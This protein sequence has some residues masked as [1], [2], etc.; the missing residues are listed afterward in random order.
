MSNFDPNNSSIN[1][2]QQLA[3][4]DGY[5]Q[6]LLVIENSR[7][8]IASL[9]NLMRF[10]DAKLS[11]YQST[12]KLRYVDEETGKTMKFVDYFSAVEHINERLE[13]NKKYI[14]DK[15]TMNKYIKYLLIKYQ[16]L[17]S[18]Y[19]FIGMIPAMKDIADDSLVNAPQPIQ[20]MNKPIARVNEEF[21]EEPVVDETMGEPITEEE[22]E[23]ELVEQPIAPRPRPNRPVRPTKP[24]PTPPKR[25]A[26]IED[27][28]Y[29]YEDEDD[30]NP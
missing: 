14:E 17:N 4:T 28:D 22:D 29:E 3:T 10:L 15:Q 19:P 18:C 26:P 11:I 20:R 25:P 1:I 12:M 8:K 9:E 6:Q 21:F 5:L 16:L 24:L 27:D 2:G 7:D 13:F 30:E 23:E